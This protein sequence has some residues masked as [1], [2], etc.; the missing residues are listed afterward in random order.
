MSLFDLQRRPWLGALLVA[1]C[2]LVYAN[3]LGGMFVYDDFGTIR[4]NPNIE[5]LWP[6]SSSMSAPPGSGA[7]GRPI[8]ALSLAINYAIG[9]HEVFG[10]HLFNVLVHVLTGLALFGCVRW[11]LTWRAK[12][13][14]PALSPVLAATLLAGLW[15]VHPL[16]S[17]ALNHVTYRNEALL[18]LFYLTCLYG[19]IRAQCADAG[20]GGTKPGPWLLLSCLSCAVA[21]GCKEIA[22]SL[23]LVVLAL[24]ATLFEK[25]WWQTLRERRLYYTGLGGTWLLLAWII[26]TGDRGESVGVGAEGIGSLDYLQ[27]QAGVLLHYL[28]LSFWP[29]PLVLDYRD[30]AVVRDWQAALVPGAV[31]LGL[32]AV[33]AL[34][35]LRRKVLGALAIACFAVLAPTS[36]FIPITGAIAAEH[37]MYLP[38]TALVLLVG[39]FVFQVCR[40]L[41]LQGRRCELVLS[42]FALL[43]MAPL[44]WTTV[45][46]N[47]DYETGISIWR[48]TVEKRPGNSLAWSNYASALRR[49]GHPDE[50]EQALRKSIELNPGNHSALENLG[51]LMRERGDLSASIDAYRRAGEARPDIGLLQMKL[52]RVLLESGNLASGLQALDRGLQLGLPAN[53]QVS[54]AIEVATVYA[55]AEESNLRNGPRALEIAQQLNQISGGTKPQHLSL[56]AAAFAETGRFAEA[57]A[58][59]EKAVQAAQSRGRSN[60][61]K[62]LLGQLEAF[63]AGRPWRQER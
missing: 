35:L 59:A 1:L 31:V 33:A 39:A 36:S 7:S 40:R 38:L 57:I 9:G 55:T 51:I 47:K 50:S 22:V 19:A 30:W 10:Y 60:L 29:D 37:R 61:A 18:A 23:P 58:T 54:V 45:Q 17:A 46:R 43:L 6:L 2:G 11:A 49:R 27:T 13:A 52:G 25:G 15:M 8:V 32:F 53:E 26:S 16:N 20:L 34:A 41:G 48:D 14:E 24:S 5:S 12:G 28:R 62:R 44:A 3:S 4:G 42:L 21:M 63:Q 56:L